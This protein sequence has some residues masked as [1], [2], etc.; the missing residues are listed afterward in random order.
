VMGGAPAARAPGQARELVAEVEAHLRA[1]LRDVICG[2][3]EPDLKGVADE[4]LLE[5]TAEPPGEITARDLRAEAPPEPE[6]ELD[7]EPE[8][9]LDPEPEPEA[10][11]EP[12]PDT[13]ELEPV[14][15][16]P[17]LEGVTPS[18]DWSWDEPEDYSA[19]V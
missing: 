14:A 1:L 4:I 2:Y 19:P 11:P 5:S 18:A 7:P 9:E 16:Q 12:E 17:P 3:L 15:A 13:S 10:D 6:P 8:P